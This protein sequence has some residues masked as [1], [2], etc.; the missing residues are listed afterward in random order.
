[1]GGF[2]MKG[3]AR[4]CNPLIRKTPGLVLEFRKSG[5]PNGNRAI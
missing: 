4:D 3:A 1:M 5:E 2:W